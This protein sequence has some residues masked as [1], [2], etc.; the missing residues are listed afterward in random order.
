MTLP[1]WRAWVFSGKAFA[2]ACLALYLALWIDLP[3]P[4]W[5]VTTVYVVS[6]P[7]AG[8]T[9]SK[10]VYRLLGTALGGVGA[11]LLVPN[12]VTS[13]E[14]LTVG[15]S[16][17]TG[18]C[19]LLSLLDRR[20]HSYIFMLAGYTAPIIGF[21]AVDDPGGIFLTAIARVQ[22]IGLGMVC[23]SLV[24]T[25]VLPQSVGQAFAGR[26]ESWLGNAALLLRDAVRDPQ[27]PP[28]G[29]GSAVTA[30]DLAT[31]AIEIDLLATHLGFDPASPR[32]ARRWAEMLRSRMLLLLPLASSVGNRL[33]ALPAGQRPAFVH[34]AVQAVR[35]W[36]DE[37]APAAGAASAQAAIDRARDA[38]ERPAVPDWPGILTANLLL[39]LRELV[40]L[41]L[42]CQ[43]L[44]RH[45]LGQ[46]GRPVLAAPGLE[47]V[48]GTR[49][50]H[51]DLGLA[52]R[53]ASAAVL[54][55][56]LGSW[57]W[58][59][60]AWP[61]GSSLPVMAAVVC[62]FF[63]ALDSPVRPQ[64]AFAWWT[65]VAV[66]VSA[67]YVFALLPLAHDYETVVLLLAPVLLGAGLV[68]ANPATSLIGLALC[69][70]IPTLIGLQGR[71]TGDFPS[72]ANGGL[73]LVGGLCLGAAVTALARVFQ[74][75]WVIQRILRA[76]WRSLAR[77]AE[78]R[79]QGNRDAF[80]SLLLDRVGQL[81]PRQRIGQAAGLAGGQAGPDMMASIRIGLNIV[82]LRRARHHLPPALLRLL[83][84]VLDGLATE[85]RGRARGGDR[86]QPLALLRSLDAT[87]AEAAALPP[88]PVRD[89]L[90]MGLAGLRLSLFST[91]AAPAPFGTAAA[92][93]RPMVAA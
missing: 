22:E 87:L 59:A 3:R 69:A 64:L 7:F 40:D 20:P 11:V 27:D 90:L 5:A 41:Q 34:D 57:F 85:F 54:A 28:Q 75:H 24:G 74:P 36:L 84:Q 33:A 17:W 26:V 76:S 45:I 73:A 66:L 8:P 77:A 83:D 12:L 56:L 4:Y 1:G 15:L 82:D 37:G 67:G 18:I 79:G 48:R 50:R 71:Y 60:T 49:A 42:D 78:Q 39:R 35:S 31:A 21:P 55:M 16:L 81:A 52:L 13:P 53:S 43:T 23:A 46:P 2:A 62:S 29:P 72:F 63:S 58:I 68:A 9:L 61:E 44:A 80:T 25:I 19:L 93:P 86:P 92:L 14:L 91:E 47:G 70:N 30:A 89:D 10:A 88:G 38:A 32:Q 65:L 6:H 51:A